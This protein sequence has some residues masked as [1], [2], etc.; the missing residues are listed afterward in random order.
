MSKNYL[1][2][3]VGDTGDIHY[4]SF[5]DILKTRKSTGINEGL[6]MG[7]TIVKKIIQEMGGQITYSNRPTVFSLSLR[8]NK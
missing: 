2:L 5:E 7:L 8:N 6:G 4:G 3:D 1:K